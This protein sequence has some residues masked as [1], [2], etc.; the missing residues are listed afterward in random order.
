MSPDGELLPAE[1]AAQVLD[2]FILAMCAKPNQ[3]VK[4]IICQQVVIAKRVGTEITLGKNGFLFP[5]WPFAHDPGDDVLMMSG[6]LPPMT[7]AFATRAIL[8][9]F[10]LEDAWFW[11]RSRGLLF[12]LAASR[13]LS[14]IEGKSLGTRSG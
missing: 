11:G 5:A 1:L 6:L 7:W 3:G 2:G 4:A 8:I 9:R 14:G 13:R 10:W 12:P